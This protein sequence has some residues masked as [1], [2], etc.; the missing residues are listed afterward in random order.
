[1]RL[2]ILFAAVFCVVSACTKTA[3]VSG[4]GQPSPQG[5][6]KQPEVQQKQQAPQQPQAPAPASL[7][8]GGSQ[9]PDVNPPAV[10][11]VVRQPVQSQ[12]WWFPTVVGQTVQPQQQQNPQQQN[13]QQQQPTQPQPPVVVYQDPKLPDVIHLQAIRRNY[14]A[15][16]KTCL[17]IMVTADGYTSKRIPIGCNKDT[18]PPQFVDLPAKKGVCNLIW[19]QAETTKQVEGT[20]GSKP[21][22][23]GNVPDYLIH[24]VGAGYQKYMMFEGPEASNVLAYP[25]YNRLIHLTPSQQS[26]LSQVVV[27]ARAAKN[28]GQ[29]WARISYEDQPFDSVS[30][31]VVAGNWSSSVWNDLGIDYNDYVLDLVGDPGISFKFTANVSQTLSHYYAQEKPPAQVANRVS[32]CN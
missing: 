18:S 23:F 22:V 30:K 9:S 7:P 11:V 25:G 15:W 16:W 28:A 14:D 2:F 31:Y 10:T 3:F 29:S 19:F 12:P 5:S 13:P 6:L 32:F 1:M 24:S 17:Y 8:P 21:C 26:E 20:C 27:N 4:D